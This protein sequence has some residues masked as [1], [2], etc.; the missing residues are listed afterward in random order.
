MADKMTRFALFIFAI[1]ENI[2]LFLIEITIIDEDNRYFIEFGSQ[3]R[4][5]NETFNRLLRLC[6]EKYRSNSLEIFRFVIILQRIW[7]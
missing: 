4:S 6:Y 5:Y 2:Q 3:L 7:N 1:A